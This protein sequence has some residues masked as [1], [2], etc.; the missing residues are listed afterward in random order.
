VRSRRVGRRL[1]LD[2]REVDPSPQAVE[3]V[4]GDRLVL[5][6]VLLVDSYENLAPVDGWFRTRFLPGLAADALTVVAGRDARRSLGA[7]IRGGAGWSRYGSF[8]P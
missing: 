6:S 2:G 1:V 4:L 5:G 8:R 7:A 3:A